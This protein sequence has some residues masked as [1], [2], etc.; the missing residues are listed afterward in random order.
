[1]ITYDHLWWIKSVMGVSEVV[2]ASQ[3][4]KKS[5]NKTPDVFFHA[6]FDYQAPRPRNTTQKLKNKEN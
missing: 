6:V 5:Q 3:L 4:T 1:M 2:R